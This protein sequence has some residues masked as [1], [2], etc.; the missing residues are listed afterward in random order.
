MQGVLGLAEKD[1]GDVSGDLGFVLSQR[2]SAL[3]CREDPANA[4]CLSLPHFAGDDDNSTDLVLEFKVEVDGQWGPYLYCN[5][6]NNSVP[7]GEWAC[8]PSL[9]SLGPAGASA[10]CS[11]T[12]DAYPVGGWNWRAFPVP[13]T[14]SDVG[15]PECCDAAGDA[16]H[17]F[18]T[19]HA[20][21][22]T[23]VYGGYP[24]ASGAVYTRDEDSVFAMPSKYAP[25]TCNCTR[26]QRSVGIRRMT[27]DYSVGT[28]AWCLSLLVLRAVRGELEDET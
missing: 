15:L 2:T 3:R 28:C 1:S 14:L 11:A 7:T 25:P 6:V 27:P 12:Y 18:W 23:C 13:K 24:P 22:R 21:N 4:M 20:N 8:L 9:D 10:T 19:Y 5:P 17:A 26:A 16:D